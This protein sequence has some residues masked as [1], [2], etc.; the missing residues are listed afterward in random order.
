[1]KFK[2]NNSAILVVGVLSAVSY[3]AGWP[4]DLIFIVGII[5]ILGLSYEA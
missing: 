5:L 3:F 1:M 4:T 2:I